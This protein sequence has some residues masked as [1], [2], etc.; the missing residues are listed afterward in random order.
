MFRQILRVDRRPSDRCGIQVGTPSLVWLFV[1]IL[2][3]WPTL[4]MFPLLLVMYAK[5][6]MTE[7]AEMRR[8]FGEPYEV[9]AR[10][11]PRFIPRWR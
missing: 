9:Y 11:T 10:R 5:L 2:L 1:M 4:L 6:S 8:Q 3:Q 7:E